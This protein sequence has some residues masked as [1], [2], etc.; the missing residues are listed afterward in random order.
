MLHYF[1]IFSQF[2][3]VY[4][5]GV[6][7]FVHSK[8]NVKTKLDN[9]ARS[10]VQPKTF[11]SK[12]HF[13]QF[14]LLFLPSYQLAIR[15]AKNPSVELESFLFY[16]ILARNASIA[17][18]KQISCHLELK[19]SIRWAMNHRRKSHILSRLLLNSTRRTR[20]WVK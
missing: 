18:D 19:Y 11:P 13:Y 9:F 15:N 14:L 8:V 17:Q 2:H 3:S 10:V 5:L 7:F 1:Y 12:T 6:L 4:S 20:S 16:Y